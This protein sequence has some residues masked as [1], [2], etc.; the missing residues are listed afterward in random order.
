ALPPERA[1]RRGLSCPP[2]AV[3]RHVGQRRRVAT[4][5]RERVVDGELRGAAGCG[6]AMWQV[7]EDQG[8]T[9]GRVEP[10]TGEHWSTIPSCGRRIRPALSMHRPL[11]SRT[12]QGRLA[13]GG[14]WLWGH[15][16]TSRRIAHSTAAARCSSTGAQDLHIQIS[17]LEQFGAKVE[18]NG[19]IVEGTLLPRL[20]LVLTGPYPMPSADRSASRR[21]SRAPLA[22]TLRGAAG[23]PPRP[24]RRGA[25]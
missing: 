14:E 5:G 16:N 23:A 1:R 12:W 8:E 2:I 20:R 19:H 17:D 15:A 11:S 22:G 24:T 4:C 9:S 6:T 18:A 3:R 25:H 21:S 13:L 10:A 7:Q